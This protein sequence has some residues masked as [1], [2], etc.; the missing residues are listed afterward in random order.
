MNPSSQ[1]S[2]SGDTGGRVYGTTHEYEP[3]SRHSAKPEAFVAKLTLFCKRRGL[4]IKDL[5]HMVGL[6]ESTFYRWRHGR[7]PQLHQLKL[8]SEAPELG[9]A[10]ETLEAWLYPELYQE[11]VSSQ[12]AHLQTTSMPSSTQPVQLPP[13]LPPTEVVRMP[14]ALDVV[15]D[16]RDGALYP[17]LPHE[18][19]KFYYPLEAAPSSCKPEDIWVFYLV[20][21]F[22]TF[23]EKTYL[24]ILPLR[25]GEHGLGSDVNISRISFMNRPDV[26]FQIIASFTCV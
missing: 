26:Y 14:V 2:F 16:V 17:R 8:L 4:R 13:S 10:F 23:P 9:I 12:D 24:L 3:R 11:S 21:R 25:E 19:Q 18:F 7:V 5:C 15:A 22:K 1:D 6:P 20:N